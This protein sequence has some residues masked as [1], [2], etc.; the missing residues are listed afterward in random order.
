MKD[1]IQ[2]VLEKIAEGAL[3]I[4]QS[5][6]LLDKIECGSDQEKWFKDNLQNRLSQILISAAILMDEVDEYISRGAI[7]CPEEDIDKLN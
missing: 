7:L 1:K 4:D 6:N 5:R 2:I 3:H